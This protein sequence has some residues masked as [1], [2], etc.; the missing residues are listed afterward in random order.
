MLKKV[1]LVVLF[2]ALVLPVW[3]QL[4]EAQKAA[5]ESA[6]VIN[7]KEE[8]KPKINYSKYWTKTLMTVSMKGYI[9]GNANYKK[10]SMIWNSRLQLDYGFIYSAD[11]PFTQKSND[12]IYLESKWG[13][14]AFKS[15]YLSAQYSF[16]SQFTNSW[17]YLNPTM[18]ADIPEDEKTDWEPTK[19]DWMAKRQLA[20][21]LFSPAYTNLALGLDAKPFV[22]LTVNFA[23]LTG[24][25]VI[26]NN[27]LLRGNYGME[28]LKKYA[29]DET[30][31]KAKVAELKAAGK[32]KEAGEY[33]KSS[34]FE[35]GAQ[36][37]VD[38]K[39]S[40]NNNFNYNTQL[41]LFSDYLDNPQNIRVNWDNR[42]DFKLA[43][44][45]SLT[46]ATNLIYDDKILI[47]NEKEVKKGLSGK[48]RV[49]F[50]QSLSFGFVY[51]FSNIKS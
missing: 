17:K 23:P 8:E 22:W 14:Q 9:D 30:G 51:T 50:M 13:Y 47:R 43:K 32:L 41:I 29:N 3:G 4:T 37:K 42:F 35:F 38:A 49:Q 46:F 33:Y 11:K 2:S 10:N 39:V 24:G 1:I 48:Q 25:F 20:S 19:K 34:R 26:V 7:N 6:N 44:Y 21:G 28:F 15:V 31:A 40:V 36:L 16:K 5:L 12:R 45:F 27:P 18:P